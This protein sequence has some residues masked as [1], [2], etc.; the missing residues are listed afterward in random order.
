MCKTCIFCVLLL[1]VPLVN[2]LQ[3]GTSASRNLPATF[4]PG[5]SVQVTIN[6]STDPANPPAAVI[7]NETVPEGWTISSA[8]PSYIKVIGQTYTWLQYSTSGVSSFTISYT[9]Q[10]PSNAAGTCKFSG[11][12]SASGEMKIPIS[13]S[14]RITQVNTVIEPIFSPA[15]GSYT[16]PVNVSLSC[17]TPGATIRYTT[18]GSDPGLTS[19]LY[20]TPLNLTSSCSLKARAYKSGLNPSSVASATYTVQTQPGSISGWI[21]YQGNC[22]GLIFIYL[23]PA[24]SYLSVPAYSTVS[25]GPG[26]FTISSVSTGCYYLWAF[27]DANGDGLFDVLT[28]PSHFYPDN[29]VTVLPGQNLSSVNF[30]LTEAVVRKGDLNFDGTVNVIDV[31]LCLRM[32]TESEVSLGSFTYQVPY[33]E[34]LI[35][36][37]DLNQDASID[38]FDLIGILQLALGAGS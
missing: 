24:N 14:Q 11:T 30:S 20:T 9:I 28:E 7:V 21:D 23:L 6:V 19:P 26:P 35:S 8:V 12:I 29:P 15:P 33:P 36:A 38:I 2:G 4:V 3:A 10:I 34:K 37:A 17:E 27:L 13:G 25:P 32:A 16:S 1:L 31:V 5:G 18:D 22:A